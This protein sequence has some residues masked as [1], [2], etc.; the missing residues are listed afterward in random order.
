MFFLLSPC[1]E[2]SVRLFGETALPWDL[3]SVLIQGEMALNKITLNISI[4]TSLFYSHN[5]SR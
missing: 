4:S 5:L 2:G 1:M 3:L